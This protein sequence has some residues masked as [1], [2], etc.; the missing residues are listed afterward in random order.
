MSI[1]KSLSFPAQNDPSSAQTNGQT[2]IFLKYL[3][4][5]RVIPFQPRNIKIYIRIYYCYCK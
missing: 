4:S 5:V 3:Y 2:D 1:R